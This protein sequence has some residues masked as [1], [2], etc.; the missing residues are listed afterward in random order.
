[1]S[2]GKWEKNKLFYFA[3]IVFINKNNLQTSNVE[4]NS[5][6]KTLETQLP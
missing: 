2:I 1:M 4:S 3:S 6:K 5:S